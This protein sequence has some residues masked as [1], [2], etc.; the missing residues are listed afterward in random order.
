MGMFVLNL[1]G[2]GL[3]IYFINLSLYT[4][5]CGFQYGMGSL[6]LSSEGYGDFSVSLFILVHMQVFC[7]HFE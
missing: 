6:S 2:S 7:W 5:C 4:S 3:F 1:R